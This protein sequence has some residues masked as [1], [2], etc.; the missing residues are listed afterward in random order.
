MQTQAWQEA[1]N[2]LC[3]RLDAMGDLL[4]TTPAI[5]A[6]KESVPGRRITLLAS[7]EG[8][9]VASSIGLFDDVIIYSAPWL[10]ASGSS[11]HPDDDLKMIEKL[12]EKN[13]D[14]AVI[15]TVYSQNP[16]PS[17]LLCY[18]SGIPLRASFCRENP[19]SLLTHWVK[20]DEPQKFV[21]HEVRRHLD[22]VAHLGCSSEDRPMV[23][24]V[25]GPSDHSLMEK[26]LVRGLLEKEQ[27]K[28][29]VVHPG[30]TASSRRFHTEGFS[31]VCE[32]LINE[33]KTVIFTGAPSEAMISR[34]IQKKMRGENKG[35]NLSGEL[36][37]EE[38]IALLKRSALLISNNSGP[39][40]MAAALGTPVVDIYALTNPQH[41]P[42]MVKHSLLYHEVSC[43]YCY[44]SIC[45]QVH[46]NCINLV[47]PQRIFEE[48]IKLFDLPAHQKRDH[49]A[50]NPVFFEGDLIL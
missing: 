17:A 32:L 5:E 30:S 50:I 40:H 25:N 33:G 29:V 46:N 48:T 20:E 2:I 19:Y 14:G 42:W 34:E 39:V 43:A 26:L 45:P 38:L 27:D 10:K 8:G 6:M 22:L 41:T 4:M 44:K 28:W 16:L 13:F 49:L 37:L 9:R 1:K 24:N 21:R 11:I 3:I 47:S 18:L 23:L 15:F 36:E 35:I 12:K 7:K 31:R